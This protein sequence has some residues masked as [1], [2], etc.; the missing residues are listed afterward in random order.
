MTHAHQVPVQYCNTKQQYNEQC[1]GS[2]TD[3][4]AIPALVASTAAA[5]AA[6]AV[7]LSTVAAAG[8]LSW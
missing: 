6:A 3:K 2:C 1:L 5:P 8:M 4:L 7:E